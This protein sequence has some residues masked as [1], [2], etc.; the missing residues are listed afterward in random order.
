MNDEVSDKKLSAKGKCLCGAITFSAEQVDPH[1]HA[2]HC[3]MC[4]NWTGGP[5]LSA[6]ADGVVFTGEEHLGRYQSSEWAER[7]FCTKCGSSLFYKLLDQSQYIMC[8]GAFDDG[9]PLSL[10]GEIYIDEKPELYS[11]VGDHPRMTGAEFLA[12]MGV[13]ES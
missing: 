9:T 10:E 11:F 5:A 7:G 3:S 6:S 13:P 8:T 1:V 12:S 4:R 2:C